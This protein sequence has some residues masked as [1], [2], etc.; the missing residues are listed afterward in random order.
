LTGKVLVPV[1]EQADGT[2]SAPFLDNL[3][4]ARTP[5]ELDEL[6]RNIRF[7]GQYIYRCDT[8]ELARLNA[9]PDYQRESF[10]NVIKADLQRWM[11]HADRALG[12]RVVPCIGIPGNDDE[13][14]VGEI[15]ASA[16]T[17]VNGEDRVLEFGP[18]QLLSFGYSNPT[19]WNSPRELT[20]D[21]LSERFDRLCDQLDPGRQTLLNIHV[22]PFNSG[23]DMAPEL[24]HDLRLK[25][26]GTSSM[27]PVGSTSTTR[28]IERVQPLASFHGHVHESRGVAKLGRCVALNPGSEYN[29]GVL[30]GVIVNLAEDRVVSHQFVSA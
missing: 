30:R 23:L 15:L 19:P 3:V 10:R 9:D 17:V 22:P 4:V 27:K 29:V 11:E 24:S 21:Q 13:E 7:N 6:E 28:L 16:Q 2:F 25:G 20:E 26:G 1:T 14:F 18:F 8:D 5:T 12:E